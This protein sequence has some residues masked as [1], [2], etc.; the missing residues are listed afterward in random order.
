MD[1]ADQRL[2][3]LDDT[4]YKVESDD[5]DPSGWSVKGSDNREVGK[6][7]NLLVNIEREKVVYLDVDV[8]DSIIGED[9]EPLNEPVDEGVHE[10]ENREGEDHLII[11]IG[12]AALDEDDKS[13]YCDEI[14]YQTFAGTRR[15]KKG[16]PIDSEYE[17]YVVGRYSGDTDWD[18]REDD[19]LYDHKAFQVSE[20]RIS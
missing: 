5:P 20:Y 6:V 4:N 2:Q 18:E 16:E 9:H 19:D 10:F 11:P 12:M 13:V 3:N 8:D 1:N 17:R 15:F 14:S 7:D